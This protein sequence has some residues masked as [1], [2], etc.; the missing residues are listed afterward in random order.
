MEDLKFTKEEIDKYI[1][2]AK[3]F[4]KLAEK[5]TGYGRFCST[6]GIEKKELL[7]AI[8]EAAG[9]KIKTLNYDI[10]VFNWV[11]YGDCEFLYIERAEKEGENNNA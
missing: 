8:A 5:I 6:I 1:K 11:Y 2:L 7:L 10:G 9:Q 4:G 3:Q